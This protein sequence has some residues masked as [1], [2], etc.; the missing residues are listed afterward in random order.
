MTS[1]IGLALAAGLLWALTG[2]ICSRAGRQGLAP[3]ELCAGAGLIFAVAAWL[4]LPD[5]GRWAAG[6]AGRVGELAGWLVGGGLL[7]AAG[8]VLLQEAMRRGHQGVAWTVGQ[9]AML[10][11]C[12]SGRLVFH[13]PLPPAKLVGVG[14]LLGSLAI[15]GRFRS[16]STDP[17]QAGG[18]FYLALGAFGLMGLQQTASLIP[19]HWPQWED[20]ANLRVPLTA[21]GGTGMYCLLCRGRIA[22]GVWPFAGLLAANSLISQSLI[23]RALDRLA[24]AGQSAFGYPLAIGACILGFA[25]YSCLGLREKTS[26]A[27]IAGI[28]LGVAGL[29]LLAGGA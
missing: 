2:V 15:L 28:A 18:W 26:A 1:G 8:F 19:S 6:E 7:G 22:R 10:I 25:V 9:S 20:A 24:V 29:S 12:L 14:L 17:T 3:A 27:Q 23:Y 11:P 4:L 5:Y 16:G 21:L 13:E